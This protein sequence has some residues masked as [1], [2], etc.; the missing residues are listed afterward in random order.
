[1][2]LEEHA[3]AIEVAIQA[4]ANDEFELDDGT[5]NPLHLVE[6]NSVV[7][8]R[9]SGTGCVELTIPCSYY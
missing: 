5:G 6:L 3:H 4:A 7:A 2:T 1:M 9:I 8:G